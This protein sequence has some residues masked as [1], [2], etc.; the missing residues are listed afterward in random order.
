MTDLLPWS[1]HLPPEVDAATLDLV[2][3]RSL[4]D[5]WAARWADAPEATALVDATS[6]GDGRT[7]A[8]TELDERSTIAARRLRAA[9]ITHGDRV[10]IAG[11]SSVDYVVAYLAILRAGATALAVN[12]SYTERE[13][14]AIAADAKPKAAISDQAMIRDAAADVAP[15]VF[16]A[17]PSLAGLPAPDDAA[18]IDTAGPGDG[19]L[20]VYTSGTTGTPKGV[21]LSHANLLASAEAVR[22]AWRWQP[23]DRLVLALPLYHLHGLGVGLHG[24]L[25]TGASAL[26]QDRFDPDAVIDAVASGATMFFGVPTMWTRLAGNP[27]IEQ[28][29][30]MR[31]GVSGSAPLPADLH[32][33]I[34]ELVGRP[35]LERYGMSETAMLTSN[36]YD[37]ERRAGSVG[38]PL[39]GVDV[40]LA[41]AGDGPGEIEVRGPNVF[42][43]YLDRPEATAEAFDGGWFRTGDLGDVDADGYLHI[44]GRSKELIISGGFNVF[45]REVED[46]LRACPGVVDACVVGVPDAEW[47][48]RVTAFVVGDPDDATL[49]AWA[50]ERLVAYK[51]PRRWERIDDVPRNSM[52]KVQR[53][54]LVRRATGT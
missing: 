35:P 17:D 18:T 15:T 26:L 9:G 14:R 49:V 51:R 33:R 3:G 1:D 43:G 27:R 29:A 40:R 2:D 48:E 45:P 12:S 28:L 22:L 21:P 30:T 52:G 50:A 13:V 6:A 34:A 39:P 7:V 46:V 44:V 47:G 11:T 37:G 32:R 8:N 16:T 41:T 53:D 20:L 23:D 38:F 4:V 5:A 19:A 36:P 54:V 10:L 24:T 42:A 25:V 31:L